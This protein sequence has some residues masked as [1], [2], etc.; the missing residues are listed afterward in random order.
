MTP[1]EAFLS[2]LLCGVPDTRYAASLSRVGLFPEAIELVGSTGLRF[3]Q[4]VAAVDARGTRRLVLAGS[5][6]LLSYRPRLHVWV[7]LLKTPSV[8]QRRTGGTPHAG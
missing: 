6:G 5:T 4:D 7:L 8:R 1:L 2:E 3:L